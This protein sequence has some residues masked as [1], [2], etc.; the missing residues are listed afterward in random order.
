MV[1]EYRPSQI[2]A[3]S[4]EAQTLGNKPDAMDPDRVVIIGAI[5]GSLDAARRGPFTRLCA[6]L[7][8]ACY[9]GA[10]GRGL[11]FSARHGPGPRD[12]AAQV[13]DKT[14]DQFSRMC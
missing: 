14:V 1:V 8:P 13:L 11:R 6:A 5:E 4:P 3:K 12:L 7:C 2:D 9:P 10:P